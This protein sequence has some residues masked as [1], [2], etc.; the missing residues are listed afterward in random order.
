MK[1]KPI[2]LV[3]SIA[4]LARCALLYFAAYDAGIAFGSP[5]GEIFR[6]S[7][8]AQL[9]CALGFFFLWLDLPRYA[10]FARLLA[11]AKGMGLLFAAIPFLD[12]LVFQRR[13]WYL[14]DPQIVGP[15]AYAAIVAID[16]FGLAVVALSG[17]AA[18][19]SDRKEA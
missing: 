3:A 18:V 17:A 2:L 1:R 15:L 4:E 10:Q 11:V 9:L 8:S 16:A 12:V 5:R 7:S 13:V 14:A 19:G 6:Y